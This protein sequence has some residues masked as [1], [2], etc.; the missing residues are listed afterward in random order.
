MP[1]VFALTL[2]GAVPAGIATAVSDDL[3]K[4]TVPEAQRSAAGAI[5]RVFVN[6]ARVV[7]AIAGG[8]V[9][10]DLGFSTA[11]AIDAGALVQVLSA[12]ER[13]K[14]NL[15]HIEKRPS[16]RKNWTYT[17]FVDAQGHRDD[18]TMAAALA[19][20]RTHCRELTVLGS[21]PRSRR[22]L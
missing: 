14:I 11:F 22:I 7:G 18:P 4:L 6:L 20:A 16:G 12:F 19:D 13:A 15:T 5:E 17:F 1:V 21:Y 3:L 10:L 8:A 9:V 2:L